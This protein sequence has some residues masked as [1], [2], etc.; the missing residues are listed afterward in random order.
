MNKLNAGKASVLALA[1][2][3]VVTSFLFV[4]SLGYIF[5]S[6]PGAIWTTDVTCGGTNINIY[7]SKNDVHLNGGP[8]GGGPG[9]PDGSYYV[10]VTE[11]NGTLLGSTANASA[12]VS[13]GNFV[14][15]YNLFTLTSFATTTN[16]GGEY[17]VHVSMDN[18]F[19]GGSTKSDNFKVKA[20]DEEE[21]DVEG[22][23]DRTAT[24]F[25]SNATK[26]D[27]SCLFNGNGT[28][29][30]TPFDAC[31]NVAGI[32]TSVPEGWFKVSENSTE[33]REFQM[34]GPPTGDSSEPQGQVLGASTMAATG[35]FTENLYLGIMAIGAALTLTGVKNFKK[36]YQD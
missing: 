27:G 24:N 31:T 26:D 12:I 17:K 25:N 28:P 23:T 2:T 19:P 14:K 7:S 1:A 9:L 32:Q 21:G 5:A 35:S 29:T 13:G 10:K 22:C 11:P 15:C 6:N 36:A 4:N 16:A 8:Q 18:A 20:E 34:P 30:P 3:L 33:C